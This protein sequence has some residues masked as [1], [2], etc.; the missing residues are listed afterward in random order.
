MRLFGM[1]VGEVVTPR[2]SER[3]AMLA[4]AITAARQGAARAARASTGGG[5]RS[6]F[7]SGGDV[8]R[9]TGDWPTM[10]VPADWVVYRY[11]RT[12]VARSREQ[13]TNN[14]FVKAFMRL[15]RQNVVGAEGVQFQSLAVDAKGDPDIEAR[16]A[17]AAAFADWAKRQHCDV[18][19]KLSWRAIQAACVE[20]CARDGE[21]FVRIITGRQFGGKYGFAL[22]MLDPQRCPVDFDKAATAE[23]ANYVR[24]GI[25]FNSYGKPVA[26]Y[27]NDASAD[28]NALAYS[29]AGKSYTRIP[30]EE[31]IHGFIQEMP[32]QKRGF[33]W[34]SSGLF[35]AKQ[36]SAMEDA[37]VVNARMGASKMGFIQFKDGAGEDYDDDNP[38]TL[39]MEP[40]ALPI[41]P[42]NAEFKEFNPQ[43]PNGEF[44]P[45]IKQMLRG[46]SAG[47]GVSYENLS[48]DREGVNFTSIRHGTL[49]E[50]ESHKERQDWLVDELCERVIEGWFPRALLGGRIIV[51]GK[52]LGGDQLTRLAPHAWQPRRWDWVDPQSD[53]AAAEASKNNF[54]T[55]PSTLIREKGGDPSAV[56]KQTGLDIAEMRAAGI[57]DEFIKAS[58]DIKPPPPKPPSTKEANA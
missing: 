7:G 37:A 20:T 32:G 29:Y 9:L 4:S 40:G 54:L 47:G 15:V 12:L 36:T 30:A 34:L 8:S 52:P 38:P 42:N 22:Q 48:Q 3:T 33:P 50:R 6:L 55:A 44:A 2:S 5:S 23:G 49:D 26:Y 53:T 16:A 28:R 10:P 51:K 46:L 41:L 13:A 35:R 19:G 56:W 27:F 21:F 11:Q 57:P 39:D 14:D 45:F 31:I 18:T 1:R 17:I 24:H 43:Y 25:E 58:F